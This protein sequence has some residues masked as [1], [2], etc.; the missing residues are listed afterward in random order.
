MLHER[1]PRELR[2]GENVLADVPEPLAASRIEALWAEA[3]RSRPELRAFASRAAALAEQ[4]DIER[5][6]YYPRLEAFGNAYYSNPNMRVIP[7]HDEFRSSW[8]AG[9]QLSFTFS[10]VPRTSAAA[11]GVEAQRAA[12]LAD[13]AALEDPVRM[14]IAQAREAVREAAA[15]GRASARRLAAA[16]EAYRVRRTLFQYGRAT[17][18]ELTDAETELTRARLDAIQAKVDSRVARVRLLH[19]V[20]RS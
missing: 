12:L 4:A 8:D 11:R 1:A 20:G 13:H 9:L 5:A 3:R 18:V 6:A 15:A 7:Q 19:A 14:E 17:S 16:E 2:I 10:D